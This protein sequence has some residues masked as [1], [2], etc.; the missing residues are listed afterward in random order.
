MFLND[1][2]P[3]CVNK[4]GFGTTCYNHLCQISDKESNHNHLEEIGLCN[5]LDDVVSNWLKYLETTRTKISVPALKGWT[6]TAII[7]VLAQFQV[8]LRYFKY[9]LI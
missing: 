8:K 1:Q 9:L 5:R 7:R 2:E 3:G 4:E 6:M